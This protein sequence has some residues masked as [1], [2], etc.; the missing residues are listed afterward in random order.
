MKFKYA[1]LENCNTAKGI[2]VVI[3]ISGAPFGLG[4]ENA[5]AGLGDE[6]AAC[7]E[8]ILAILNG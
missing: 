6:D 2:V 8:Y 4:I 3:D 7:A 5:P 1:T